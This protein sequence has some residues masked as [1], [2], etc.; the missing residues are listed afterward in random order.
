MSNARITK[1]DIKAKLAEI[2]GEATTT[3]EGAKSQLLA[4][5]A[6]VGVALVVVAF[7][8]GRRGGQRRSTVIE[9]RRV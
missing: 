8:I 3:V 1:D 2:Q 4:V 9:V 7:L 6:G 5:A